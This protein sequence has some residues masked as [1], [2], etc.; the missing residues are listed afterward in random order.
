MSGALS[1][2]EQE[3]VDI[4]ITQFVKPPKIASRLT[5]LYEVFEWSMRFTVALPEAT[6]RYRVIECIIASIFL[7]YNFV[8]T[9]ADELLIREFLPLIGQLVVQTEQGVVGGF[10]LREEAA[11]K[12]FE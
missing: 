6:S 12:G 8:L 9:P 1:A 7:K 2:A 10:V 3:L 4:A 5:L 11:A